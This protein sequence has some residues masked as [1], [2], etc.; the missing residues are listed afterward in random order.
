MPLDPHG[1]FLTAALFCEDLSHD[2][3]GVLTIHRVV[4]SLTF[5]I[6]ADAPADSLSPEIPFTHQLGFYLVFKTDR[7]DGKH[8]V[9]LVCEHPDKTESVVFDAPLVAQPMHNGCSLALQLNMEFHRAGIRWYRV[10]LDGKPVTKVPLL[11]FFERKAV[12]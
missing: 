2:D 12:E 3:E 9:K 8:H 5:E 10:E 11:V 6:P 7:G 1:P 4:E